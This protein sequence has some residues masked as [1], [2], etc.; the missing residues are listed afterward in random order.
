MSQ[1]ESQDDLD[2]SIAVLVLLHLVFPVVGNG[3]PVVDGYLFLSF[4]HNF[5][6][7]F[8]SSKPMLLSV[9]LSLTSAIL[10]WPNLVTS[11]SG[12][13]KSVCATSNFWDSYGF[14]IQI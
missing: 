9:S 4:P 13:K 10:W 1:H 11:S 14:K 8:T 5:P 2:L 3:M 12:L 6:V 7:L